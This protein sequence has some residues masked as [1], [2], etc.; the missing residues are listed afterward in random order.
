MS[1]LGIRGPSRSD[2]SYA[3][4][5][6]SAPI[7]LANFL[8]GGSRWWRFSALPGLWLG[9]TIVISAMY[10]VSNLRNCTHMEGPDTRAG[11]HD[12]LC[13]RRP[14]AAAFVRAC[15]CPWDRPHGASDEG[16]AAAGDESEVDDAEAFLPAVVRGARLCTRP[17]TATDWASSD[18]AVGPG[19]PYPGAPVS[20]GRLL[21]H[22]ATVGTSQTPYSSSCS[23]THREAHS[24]IG[25]CAPSVLLALALPGIDILLG[26]VPPPRVLR[27]APDGIRHGG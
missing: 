18:A 17:H 1:G 6:D 5:I 16:E 26:E 25:P 27:P 24:H 22:V 19:R 13:V 10:G 11:V 9:M 12:D 15:A 21:L 8:T 23:R 3:P 20:L 2:S 7:L 4:F 14:A